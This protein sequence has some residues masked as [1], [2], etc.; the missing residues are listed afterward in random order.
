M[1]VPGNGKYEKL[2]GMAGSRLLCTF[3]KP[4][5]RKL[6]QVSSRGISQH[7]NGGR[8]PRITYPDLTRGFSFLNLLWCFTKGKTGADYY[9]SIR[10][11]SMHLENGKMVSKAVKAFNAANKTTA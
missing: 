10:Q 11:Q 6:S 1:A 5:T 7:E 4:D 2:D 9:V 3:A 8:Q